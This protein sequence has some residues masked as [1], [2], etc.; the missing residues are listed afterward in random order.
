MDFSGI[1]N[2]LFTKK[3]TDYT[4]AVL[5]LVIFSVFIMFAI[6]PSLTT[7]FSLKKEEQDLTK[8]DKLYE[9]QI[10]SIAMIQSLMEENRSDI[11]LLYQSISSSPQVNKMVDDI[12]QAATKS[13]F[14]IKKANIGEVNLF[15]SNKKSIQNLRMTIEGEGSFDNFTKF[16]QAL[17]DQRRLKT[18]QKV[19]ITRGTG[20]EIATQSAILKIKLDVE[21]YY[22]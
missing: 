12:Q 20:D 8:V 1:K 21:G 5:F 19:V 17:F 14:V 4:F 3:T 15:E 18:V 10:V 11:P 7:A 16:T 2:R 13:A 6:R 9:D 22:L